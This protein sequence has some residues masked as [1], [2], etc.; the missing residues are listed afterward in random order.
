MWYAIDDEQRVIAHG[1]TFGKCDAAALIASKWQ[2]VPGTRAPYILTTELPR[3]EEGKDRA[4][5]NS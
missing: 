2:M 3:D 5:K 1:E 4:Q